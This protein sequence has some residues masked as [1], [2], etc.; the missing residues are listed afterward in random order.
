M[1]HLSFLLI[2]L[3]A[4]VSSNTIYEGSVIVDNNSTNEEVTGTT[5]RITIVS[6]EKN[7]PED[8]IHM[9]TYDTSFMLTSGG[10]IVG[11]GV[12]RLYVDHQNRVGHEVTIISNFLS[13]V[14]VV[15][16]NV[17]ENPVFGNF[18]YASL[19][20]KI[21]PYVNILWF[22]CILLLLAILPL[23]VSRFMILKQTFTIEINAED[24]SVNESSSNGT[25]NN[26]GQII[27]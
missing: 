13:D 26:G 5:L 19:R 24:E 8:S 9:I 11:Y 3:G 25:I 2:L 27:D 18:E 10:Q 21:I 20:I 23:T 14:Y 6:L 17:A 22:G 1:L 15:C 4:L 7:L 16:L 12:S